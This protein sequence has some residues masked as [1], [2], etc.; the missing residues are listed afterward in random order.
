MSSFETQKNKT[1]GD[2]ESIFKDYF[3]DG[4]LGCPF[5]DIGSS[6]KNDYVPSEMPPDNPVDYLKNVRYFCA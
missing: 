2:G 6:L 5:I 3:K 4:Y 1:S